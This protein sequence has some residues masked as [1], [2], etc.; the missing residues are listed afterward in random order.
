MLLCY[1]YLEL[2]IDLTII[3]YLFRLLRPTDYL[4]QEAIRNPQVLNSIL[5]MLDSDSDGMITP[6]EIEAAYQN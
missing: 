4:A 3:V 6:M 5:A 2:D 1:K